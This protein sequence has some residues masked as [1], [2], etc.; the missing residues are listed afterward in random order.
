M[1]IAKKYFLICGLDRKKAGLERIRSAKNLHSSL[2]VPA[3]P[4]VG[5]RD[6]AKAIVFYDDRISHLRMT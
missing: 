4:A 1:H 2:L 3:A 5:V 6:V